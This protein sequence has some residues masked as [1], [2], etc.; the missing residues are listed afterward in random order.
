MLFYGLYSHIMHHACTS[1]LENISLHL[2]CL[3]FHM[4]QNRKQKDQAARESSSTPEE[5]LSSFLRKNYPQ[6][7]D[8]SVVLFTD[9]LK[10]SRAAPQGRRWDRSVI[11]FALNLW[12]SSPRAYEDVSSSLLLPST[13]VLQY[14]K[15]VV[16]QKPGFQDHVFQWM[17]DTAM[18]RA[19]PPHGYEGGIILDEMSLQPDLQ[20][21]TRGGFPSLVGSVDLGPECNDLDVLR[22]HCRKGTLASHALQFEFLSFHGFVFPFAH[23]ATTGVQAHHLILLFWEAVQ[24]LMEYNFKVTFCLFDGAVANRAFLKA[25]F[26]PD[27]PL[28]KNMILENLV[29]PGSYIVLGFDCK[30][31]VKRIRN[32]ILSSGHGKEFTRCLVHRYH[33]IVWQH[34]IDAYQWDCSAN[35]EMQRLHHRLT[36]EHIEPRNASKMRNHLAEECLNTDMLNLVL[37]YSQSLPDSSHLDGTIGLL[38]ATSKLVSIVSDLRPISEMAD[39]RLQQLAEV[40]EWFSVWEQDILSGDNSKSEKSKMLMSWETREDIIMCCTSL[41]QIVSQRLMSG[42][43]VLPARINSDVVENFF[44]QQRSKCHGANT[45]PTYQ[46]YTK[47]VNTII[48]ASRSKRSGKKANAGVNGAVPLNYTTSMPLNACRAAKTKKKVKQIL[49]LIY[50]YIYI[51]ISVSFT[52][53]N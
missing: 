46:Q 2:S 39:P 37:R 19:L 12:S 50:I 16:D 47:G 34:W 48:L 24:H 3:Q 17:Y 10:N 1:T 51:N 49:K 5:Q 21:S 9:M 35:P 29:V 44:C 15:N 23:F 38:K 27:P 52:C 22:Q 33:E 43:S 13:R 53:S 42:H 20:I 18:E 45:N 7:S 11:Q 6:F 25:L 31:V 30:H 28:K 26:H 32:N 40:R 8:S 41:E 4:L 14:Y 36:R